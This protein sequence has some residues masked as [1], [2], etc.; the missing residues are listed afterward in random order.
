MSE[1]RLIRY[2]N[3]DGVVTLTIDRPEKRNAMNPRCT[4][5]CMRH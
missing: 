4:G 1:P 3:N 2:E 5:R